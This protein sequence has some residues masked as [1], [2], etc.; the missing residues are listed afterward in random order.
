L[1]LERRGLLGSCTVTLV[2]YCRTTNA[3]TAPRTPRRTCC[4]YAHVLIAVLRVTRSCELFPDEFD[5]HLLQDRAHRFR[6]RSLLTRVLGFPPSLTFLKAALPWIFLRAASAPAAKWG[7]R[8]TVCAG[9]PRP[10]AFTELWPGLFSMLAYRAS[11]P[12]RKY[13]PP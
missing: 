4:P 10:P 9:L 1:P 8:K 7:N 3:S 11:S 12:I 13:L 2:L 5:L 6:W